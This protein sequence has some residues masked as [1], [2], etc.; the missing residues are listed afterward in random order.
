MQKIETQQRLS[1]S[2]SPSPKP[3]HPI[4]SSFTP[5]VLLLLR[6][7]LISLNPVSVRVLLS[8]GEAGDS[9]VVRAEKEKRT[10]GRKVRSRRECK[11][12]RRR[13][14]K[15]Y[16]HGPDDGESEVQVDGESEDEGSSDEEVSSSLSRVEDGVAE[17]EMK[18]H[19]VALG[20]LDRCRS[21]RRRKRAERER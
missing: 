2:L 5:L 21:S 14:R 13:K 7:S 18:K 17:N 3:T 11:N 15:R 10:R 1:L 16:S 6:L 9:E 4:L 20:L 19:D 12:K 8:N